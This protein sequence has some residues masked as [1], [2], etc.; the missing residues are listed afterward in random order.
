LGDPPV[1]FA[2][3]NKAKQLMN[4]KPKD[5]LYNMIYSDF[6]FRLKNKLK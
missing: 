2:N 3:I 6:K 5:N 4:W 1:L